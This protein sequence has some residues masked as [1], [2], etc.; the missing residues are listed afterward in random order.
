M[1]RAALIVPGRTLGP[2]QPLLFYAGMAAKARS[3]SV[4]FLDWQPPATVGPSATSE[5]RQA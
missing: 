3:A 2:Y 5:D 1:D 4:E